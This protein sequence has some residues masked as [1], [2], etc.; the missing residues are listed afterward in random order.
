MPIILIVHDL[1]CIV[2]APRQPSRDVVDGAFA[3]PLNAEDRLPDQ[4]VGLL[5]ASLAVLRETEQRL[6]GGLVDL[7]LLKEM[8]PALEENVLRES[9]PV[10]PCLDDRIAA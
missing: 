9:L 4:V 6:L 3:L 1:P 8:Q 7:P 10:V 5:I 2:S